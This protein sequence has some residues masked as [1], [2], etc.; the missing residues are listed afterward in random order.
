[1]ASADFRA[2]V[3]LYRA[4]GQPPVKS[5][6]FHYSG[7]K[8]HEI[9]K[10]LEACEYLP[11]HI[12]YF[13]DGPEERGEEVALEVAIGSNEEARFYSGTADLIKKSQSLSR[14][15]APK[16]YYLIQEDHLEGEEPKPENLA[17]ALNYSRFITLLE[18]LAVASSVSNN[19]FAK[20][21]FFTVPANASSGPKTIELVTQIDPSYI[22]AGSVELDIIENLTQH[23]AGSLHVP[24]RQKILRLAISEFLAGRSNIQDGLFGELVK[25]WGDVLKKYDLDLDC[26]INNFS[27][28]KLRSELADAQVKFSRELSDALSESTT[29]ALTIPLVFGALIGIYKTPDIWAAYI[30]VVGA[31]LAA[32]LVGG[33]ARSQLFQLK[34]FEDAFESVFDRLELEGPRSSGS[35]V[36]ERLSKARQRISDQQKYLKL[37]LWSIRIAAW[38]PPIGGTLLLWWKFY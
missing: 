29:K 10:A 14:G 19:I 3:E 26:Y 17:V 9:A 31:L 15:E 22:S 2:L 13:V 1:M 20:S 30:I 4:V 27:F 7:D 18:R 28:E 23:S 33:M 37:V 32:V 38:L 24:E 5:G 21:L 11:G 8:T 35:Q 12:A 34:T 25:S 36:E 6:S 16:N